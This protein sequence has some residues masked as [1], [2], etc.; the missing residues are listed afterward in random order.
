MARMKRF[1]FASIAMISALVLF[2]LL[3][4]IWLLRSNAPSLPQDRALALTLPQDRAL[5]LTVLGTSLSHKA[6]WTAALAERLASCLD[7]PVE[8]EVVARPGA[9]VDWGLTQIARLNAPDVLLVEFAIN[10]ADMRDG[11][12]LAAA[13]RM[14]EDLITGIRE[15]LPEA[16]IILMTMSPAYGL[17]GW[18]RP[19]LG[20]HYT[21]YRSL[22]ADMDVGLID[23]FPR[24][25]A[26]PR[27][28]QGLARDGLH[29]DPA[30]A[31]DVIVPVAAEIIA[32][33]PCM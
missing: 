23:L 4:G 30:T 28:A 6:P 2:G 9:A 8:I 31:T 15:T 14:H 24:W 5:R 1:R 13:R 19:R 16:Q 29:P 11:H 7:H 25:R 18:V 21:Q 27:A 32:R 3:A 20:A 26:R 12:S 22:A 10:D 17:R 33:R